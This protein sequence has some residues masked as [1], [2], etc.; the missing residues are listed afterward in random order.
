MHVTRI[1]NKY[2]GQHVRVLCRSTPLSIREMG[3]LAPSTAEIEVAELSS[4]RVSVCLKK[5]RFVSNEP[6][7]K[8]IG[9]HVLAPSFAVSFV[10]DVVPS[11][12]PKL[13]VNGQRIRLTIVSIG[14]VNCR[15][16]SRDCRRSLIRSSKMRH[17]RVDW[18]LLAGCNVLSLKSDGARNSLC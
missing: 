1:V 2:S 11:D 5:I 12:C 6:S 10:G 13:F 9:A 8:E 15:S 4:Y 3:V 7:L 18:N 14:E 16:L 17:S